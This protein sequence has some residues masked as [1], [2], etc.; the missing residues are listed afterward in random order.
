MALTNRENLIY[1][2]R[3]VERISALQTHLYCAHEW[4]PKERATTAAMGM[5]LAKAHEAFGFGDDAEIA[6]AIGRLR[7][8]KQP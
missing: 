7:E 5:A 8:F 2:S 3:E 4:G 6:E 1:L